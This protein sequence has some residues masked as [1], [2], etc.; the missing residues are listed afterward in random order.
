MPISAEVKLNADRLE[1]N[2]LKEPYTS[3][4][5]LDW[6]HGLLY[7]TEDASIWVVDLKQTTSA[8]L[9]LYRTNHSST[10]TGLVVRPDNGSLVWMEYFNND[11]KVTLMQ[12]S[13]V[14]KFNFQL[15]RLPIN[16][17]F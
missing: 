2:S 11:F 4:F 5:A 8:E 9:L 7:Y 6:V 15:G 16:S 1:L 12:A 14:F 13:Q 17:A 3:Y 10:I